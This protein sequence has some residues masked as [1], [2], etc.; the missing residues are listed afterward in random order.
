MAA[1]IEMQ[2]ALRTLQERWRM[3]DRHAFDIG[4]GI[5]TGEMV[6]GDVGGRHLMNFTVYGLQVNIASRV[7]GLNKELGT[8][9]LITRATYESVSE[10]I[11]ARGPRRMPIKGVEGRD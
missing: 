8:C 2:D 5:N 9:I 4:I 3:Q 1:A 6:V 10:D 7:E 11:Q